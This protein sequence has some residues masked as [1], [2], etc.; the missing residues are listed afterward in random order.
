MVALSQM[1]KADKV[2]IATRVYDLLGE[3]LTDKYGEE[4][5]VVIKYTVTPKEGVLDDEESAQK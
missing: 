3:I 2:R 4:Y 1:T 5:G